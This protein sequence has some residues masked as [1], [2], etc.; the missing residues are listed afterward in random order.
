M[1]GHYRIGSFVIQIVIWD[2]MINQIVK[3]VPSKSYEAERFMYE[4]ETVSLAHLLT[5]STKKNEYYLIRTSIS[6]TI[7][8][9]VIIIYRD[10]YRN[11]YY[12]FHKFFMIKLTY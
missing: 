7:I 9:T 6:I 4:I 3:I 1:T 8:N 11:L 2:D 10:K 5:N 12:Q